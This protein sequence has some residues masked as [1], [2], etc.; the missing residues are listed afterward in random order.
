L[1]DA[2]V[3][4]LLA[5]FAEETTEICG[6]ITHGLLGLEEAADP[7][8]ARTHMEG[9]ARGLHTL[10]GTSA[11]VGMDDLSSVAHKMEDLI[12]PAKKAG[13]GLPPAIVDALLQGLDGFEYCVQARAAG[14]EA[15]PVTELLEAL[16]RVAQASAALPEAAPPDA[17]EAPDSREAVVD[18]SSPAYPDATGTARPESLPAEEEGIWRV[19][20]RDLLALTNEIEHVRDLRLQVD[21]RR[22]ELT[23][24]LEGANLNTMDPEA[25]EALTALA[26]S[27]RRDTH[28]AADLVE[29]VETA[30][31][32]VA[33]IPVRSVI[34]PM[35]RTVRD[36][37]RQV[38]KEARLSV[39]GA[40]LS[41]DRR[42]L[43]GL[44]GPLLHLVR[45]AVG[46]GIETP[47]AR[48]RAGKHREGSIIVRVEQR[49]NL[50]ELSVEDDGQG[51]DT[52]RIREEG[53]LRGLLP[54]PPEE[55]P[56]SR[57]QELIFLPGFSTSGEVTPA[58]GRG[59]GL[60]VVRSEVLAL[61]GDVEVR[62]TRG[63][64]TRFR[65][66]VPIEFGSSPLLVFRVGEHRLALPILGVVAA[67]QVRRANVRGS[68]ARP[69]LLVDSESVPVCRAGALLSLEPPAP[70]AEGQ[71]A[72]IVQGRDQRVALVV[73]EILGDRD[74]VIRALPP[75]LRD[76][77]AY[78]GAATLAEGELLLVLRADWLVSQ[79][80]Q[81][82]EQAR[83]LRRALVVDD[84]LTARALH[85]TVLESGGFV[86]HTAG[87]G[88]AALTRLAAETYDLVVCDISMQGM[89][90][91]AL[92]R[93][94]RS[95][96]LLRTLP[97]ILVSAHDS[98]D[99]R[100][101]GLEAGA[102]AFLGKKECVSGRLLAE[103]TEI[104]R[105]RRPS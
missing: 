8:S 82:G 23:R 75:E 50:L 45:N 67:R 61:R 87:E 5:G 83:P 102:D 9:V 11:T 10:K 92:T 3:E 30:V 15:P 95:R 97:I 62:S 49:G 85:R 72:L 70:P 74:L 43:D 47:A 66:V 48:E 25:R 91:L 38:G 68:A 42:A 101:V 56:L 100:K 17:T 89:D 77:A 51:L 96:P 7:D 26:L 34:E 60:D 21:K 4:A 13:R 53:F 94:I 46:H 76:M 2:L 78:Q 31:R 93:E 103:A 1:A 40:E 19:R 44:R 39:V 32:A 81:V 18:E 59:V 55:V 20:S 99:E 90:G 27:L 57:I 28:L 88:R 69:R 84:S 64:G 104:M 71:P 79:T 16:S 33:T 41:I 29:A 73:D 6:Q 35:R 24:I 22:L 58:A 52:V 54:A 80:D 12:A 14:R 105:R 98:G 37:C 65:M 86:V 63:Q 36:L